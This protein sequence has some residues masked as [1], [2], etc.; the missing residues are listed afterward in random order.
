MPVCL[1]VIKYSQTAGKTKSC[2]FPL[3]IVF[4][5]SVGDVLQQVTQQ[6]VQVFFIQ[7]W[8]MYHTALLQKFTGTK[9]FAAGE[10]A[11]KSWF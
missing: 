8:K 10:K 5:E 3:D 4:L 11:I 6:Q 1:L 7:I 2:V 9:H